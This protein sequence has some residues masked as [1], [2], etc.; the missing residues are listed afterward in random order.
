MR[1]REPPRAAG[2]ALEHGEQAHQAG[3]ESRRQA[4]KDLQPRLRAGVG[5]DLRAL[6]E[7][8]THLPNITLQPLP[9]ADQGVTGGEQEAAI[10]LVATLPNEQASFYMIFM[11]FE[12]FRVFQ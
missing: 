3:N 8:P 10:R 2:A 4:G 9:T 6:V 7:R 11:T 5:D 12:F 1:R